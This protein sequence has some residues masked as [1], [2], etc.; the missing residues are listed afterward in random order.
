MGERDSSGSLDLARLF[1]Y[2]NLPLT[3]F[4][5]L[6]VELGDKLIRIWNTND[7]PEVIDW[8]TTE[9]F[10]YDLSR[11]VPF[12]SGFENYREF[13]KYRLHYIGI[14]EK[15]DSF[16]RLVVKPHDKRLRI[17]SNEFPQ[18]FGSR[19]TD[20][21]VLFFFDIKSLEIKQYQYP[22]DF[23][24]IGKNELENRLR[25]FKDAER[26]FVRILDTDYNEVKF[27]NYPNY[28]N[29][30]FNSTVERY[31]FSINEDIEFV[32]DKTTI[33]GDRDLYGLTGAYAD[34]IFVNKDDGTVE[35]VKM[36]NQG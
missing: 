33:Y 2:Y 1:K 22:T 18:N 15:N 32:T 24:E 10:L 11:K 36:K 27:K 25:I 14:S 5:N 9:K 7:V 20:E 19:I 34:F 4:G 23:N 17:L 21:I 35:L 13:T 26:A 6:D 28:M 12:F 29:S 8:F 16:N 30:L 31:S 3:D